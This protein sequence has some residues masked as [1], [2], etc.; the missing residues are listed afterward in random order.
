MSPFND[1]ST[2]SCIGF[3]SMM[4]YFESTEIVSQKPEDHVGI[5]DLPL[6]SMKY[7][8]GVILRVFTR[9]LRRSVA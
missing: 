3:L 4:I 9:K 5:Q 1:L 8:Q 2:G 6:E 7:I